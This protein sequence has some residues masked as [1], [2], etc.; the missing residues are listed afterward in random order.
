MYVVGHDE[1]AGTGRQWRI[2]KRNL[3]D[4]SLVSGFGTGGVITSNPSIAGDYAYAIAIDST[5]MYV[6]GS[7]YVPADS[8]Y[9]WRIEKRRLDNGSLET[10]FDTD[11]VVTSNPSSND[12][13]A[14][15]IAI[16]SNYIYVVGYDKTQGSANSQGRAE[17]RNLTTG[18]LVNTITSNPTGN[19]DE[20]NGI[21]IDSTGVYVA[22]TDIPAGTKE[23]RLEK[24]S[25]TNGSLI[26]SFGTN[27]VVTSN[28]N[29]DRDDMLNSIAIDSSAIYMAG[30]ASPASN[31]NQWRIEKRGL[32][33]GSLTT[34]FGTNG[35]V[36]SDPSTGND[37]I[38][39]I[40]IDSSAIYAVGF[41]S[42]P[43]A[44][45]SQWRIEKRA[46]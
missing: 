20:A 35:V 1:T 42:T 4:G 13:A 7:E 5:Y 15:N 23:W 26:T 11:G 31:N 8:S 32:T 10:T 44:G 9:Q 46:K 37:E 22:G 14:Y 30:W 34:T 29:T 19:N 36:T 41:D 17:V 28:P 24:R 2:E 45:D 27:G 43:G 38:Y 18:A 25:L 39:G 12:D 40:A 3:S 16:D 6:V 33:D 21:K